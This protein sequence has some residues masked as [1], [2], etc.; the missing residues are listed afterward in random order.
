MRQNLI[1]TRYAD[2]ETLGWTDITDAQ[3]AAYKDAAKQPEGLITVGRLKEIGILG[4][5]CDVPEETIVFL[6]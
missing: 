5:A 2:G 3:F 4:I 1:I 6:I